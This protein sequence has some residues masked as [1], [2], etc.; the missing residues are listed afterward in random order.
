MGAFAEW[1]SVRRQG[2]TVGPGYR[3]ATRGMERG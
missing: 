2:P 3:A 1:A